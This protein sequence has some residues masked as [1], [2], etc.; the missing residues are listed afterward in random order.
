MPILEELEQNKAKTKTQ[1]GNR[2]SLSHN[3]KKG[4]RK[5]KW[6][7]RKRPCFCGVCRSRPSTSWLSSDSA[8]LRDSSGVGWP[9]EENDGGAVGRWW[10]SWWVT[11]GMGKWLTATLLS[12]LV[13]VTVTDW[14]RQLF[15][16]L[17]RSGLRIFLI[18]IIKEIP[19][20]LQNRILRSRGRDSS[21]NEVKCIDWKW[22]N[23]VHAN[24]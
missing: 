24:N 17:S 15:A 6:S 18:K 2:E 22:R 7:E 12:S 3:V 10:S 19:F 8:L 21:S 1:V 13:A 5:C 23:R 16:K 20:T 9:P 14:S 4:E 11:R